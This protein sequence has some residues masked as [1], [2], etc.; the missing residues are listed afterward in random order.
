MSALAAKLRAR[1]A[2]EGPLPVDAFMAACLADPDHGYYRGGDR[3]GRAGDFVT[4]PEISQVFGELLGLWA[5]EMWRLI[6][7]PDPVNLVEL[8]PGRGTLMADALRAI[9]KA[10]PAFRDA[11]RVR[12]VEISP[13]FR[14]LQQ[15]ALG[16]SPTWHDSLAAVPDGPAIVLANEYFDALPVKQFV[17]A[18]DGWRER[19]VSHD[20]Q[21][22]R[23]VMSPR[24]ADPPLGDAHR[25]A[26]LG[27]LVEISPAAQGEARALAASLVRARGAALIIDYGSASGFVGETLQAVSRH[28][29]VDPLAEPG[30]ADLTAH[31]DFAALA[32]AAAAAGAWVFGPVQQGA[33]LS[34]LG[35]G[36]RVAALLAG[37]GAEPG[38]AIAR[39]AQRLIDPAEMG[40]LFKTLALVGPRD[41]A[42]PGFE[43]P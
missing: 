11:L 16:P 8:G 26:A 28:R 29:P 6:G 36:V 30:E 13:G 38:R 7:G 43:A 33:F 39:A 12:L 18:E 37:A 23:F 22:F 10:A 5:A 2:A 40:T 1:I 27:Q 42:P 17:R 35:L 19:C 14:A 25:A 24:R 3:L 32:A 9:A 41:I 21:G 31:V 34:R 4:A 15:A 20:G